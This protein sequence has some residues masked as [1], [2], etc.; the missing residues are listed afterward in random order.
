MPSFKLGMKTM[1]ANEIEEKLKTR[2]KKFA[3]KTIGLCSKIPQKREFWNITKQLIRS[4]S[5]VG[6]NYRSACRAKSTADFINKLAIVEEET[7]ESLYWLEL[8]EEIGIEKSSEL[9][10]LKNEASELVSIIVTSK[11]TARW[12]YK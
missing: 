7:D 11:K 12:N 2:T 6:A 8:L 10:E 5:S 4:A 9:K 3:I 1:R